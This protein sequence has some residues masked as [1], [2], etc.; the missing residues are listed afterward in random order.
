MSDAKR[1][2]STIC[3]WQTHFTLILRR[4]TLNRT[5]N[6]GRKFTCPFSQPAWRRVRLKSNS[7]RSNKRSPSKLTSEIRDDFLLEELAIFWN[8]QL[9]WWK[10]VTGSSTLRQKSKMSVTESCK[11]RDSN[12]TLGQKKTTRVKVTWM[13]LR[14]WL[15]QA[16]EAEIAKL[17]RAVSEAKAANLRQ[18]TWAN[19]YDKLE[20]AWIGQRLETEVNYLMM[21]W[22]YSMLLLILGDSPLANTFRCGASQQPWWGWC[23]LNATSNKICSKSL[24]CDASCRLSANYHKPCESASSGGRAG[25]SLENPE[26]L[27]TSA[28]HL[29]LLVS[30]HNTAYVAQLEYARLEICVVKPAHPRCQQ[31]PAGLRLWSEICICR[32]GPLALRGCGVRRGNKKMQTWITWCARR[33]NLL[34]PLRN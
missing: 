3:F 5:L 12:F 4:E 22:V 26:D 29:K 11:L 24:H 10:C 17:Q 28:Q 18:Q 31:I 30:W 34:A 1:Q 6:V 25:S 27:R 21:C 15:R 23:N 9:R 2:A 8:W 7:K 16:T 20:I 14:M 33:K 19:C 13:R 32:T